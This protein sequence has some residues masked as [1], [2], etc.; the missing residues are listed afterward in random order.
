MRWNAERRKEQGL[1]MKKY[2]KLLAMMCIFGVLLSG[3][4]KDKKEE[5]EAVPLTIYEQL[6]ITE[7]P[8]ADS[9]LGA[10]QDGINDWVR[11]FLAVDSNVADKK[12]T[13]K[14]LYQSISDENQKKKLKEEREAF[15][16]D[17][18]VVIGDVSTELTSTKK[19]KYSDK[20]VG[21]VDCKTTIRGTK[22]EE[23]FEKSYTMQMVVNYDAYV[24]SVFE[25]KNIT[26]E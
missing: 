17:S 9:Y 7:E 10:I 26:W 8:V 13:D 4:G 1:P 24:M 20:E 2:I 18:T 15:Y 3:C 14:G 21:V 22:N 6:E 11:A 19:A 25:V 5:K 23:A 16:K 12:A